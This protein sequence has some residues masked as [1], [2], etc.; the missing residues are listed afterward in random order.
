MHV[1]FKRN[2]KN[3]VA[4]APTRVGYT[5]AGY[6][7]TSAA[8]GGTQY[9]DAAMA[10]ARAWNKVGAQTL[11]ARWAAKTYTA[12]F[13]AGSGTPAQQ[14]VDQTYDRAYI[15]PSSTPVRTGYTFAG[16]FTAQNGGGS[17]VTTSVN[18]Q[19]DGA[20]TL[21]AKWVAN[22]FSV[23]FNK[24]NA[25]AT[26]TMADQT[27]TYDQ[28][29]ALT[30]NTFRSTGQ[31]MT[32]WSTTANGTVAYTD[33]TVVSNLIATA[34]GVVNLYALWVDD[35][36]VYFDAQGGTT[37]VPA[38][39][40]VTNGLAYGPL[41]V[42]T[43][44]G[45]T[46]GGWFTATNGQGALIVSNTVVSESHSRTLYAGWTAN[47]YAT[48]FVYNN[49]TPGSEVTNQTYDARY[50]LPAVVPEAQTGFYFTGWWTEL[51]GAIDEI[52]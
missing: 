1:L 40:V 45:Y 48:T 6:W 52:S 4:T 30:A 29:Q 2:C 49:G 39:I 21:Y 8:S 25:S 15:L 50:H 38:S 5:F 42:T 12:T 28:A 14:A 23:R 7:D 32:G 31:R 44:E 47:T 11:W 37:P 18:F 33:G 20:V 46:F 51:N 19:A 36:I 9:Y 26:G 3:G 10:S 41:A 24:N 34:S 43:R 17:Q 22:A 16:W 27:F 13:N 35:Q